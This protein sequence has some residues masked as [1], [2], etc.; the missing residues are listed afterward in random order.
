MATNAGAKQGALP[1]VY[2]PSMIALLNVRLD[3]AFQPEQDTMPVASAV[4]DLVQTLSTILPSTQKSTK[5]SGVA[6]ARDKLSFVTKVVPKQ[7][8][9]ELPSY[10][11]AGKFSMTV[12]FRDIPLD[13]RQIRAI[14]V[15]LHLGTV[16]AQDFARGVTTTPGDFGRSSIL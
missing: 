12:D 7:C 15:E 9:V 8:S 1:A 16:S 2:Y 10:R 13:P 3:E 14:G 11:Q 6:G 5:P 4:D